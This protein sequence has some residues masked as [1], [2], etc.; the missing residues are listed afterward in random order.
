MNWSFAKY[1]PPTKSLG[2]SIVW[3]LLLGFVLQLGVP[4]LLIAIGLKDTAWLAWFPGAAAHYLGDRRLVCRHRHYRIHADIQYQHLG[5][6]RRATSWV[7]RLFMVSQPNSTFTQLTI[8]G[9]EVSDG[10]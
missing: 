6:R 9:K 8:C 4:F 3:S 5:V 10:N 7:A 1:W 2:R